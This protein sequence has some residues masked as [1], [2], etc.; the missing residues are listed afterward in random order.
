MPLQEIKSPFSSKQE[1]T[2]LL[3]EL[4]LASAMPAHPNVVHYIRGWQ[5][6]RKL[7]IQMEL[8]AAGNLDTLLKRSDLMPEEASLPESMLWLILQCA[9][10]PACF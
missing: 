3:Q 6:G 7:H 1:R 2:E 9:P 5:E 4:T 10:Q 8:C